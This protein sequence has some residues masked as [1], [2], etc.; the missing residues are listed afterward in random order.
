MDDCVKHLVEVQ[1][2][3]KGLHSFLGG[4]GMQITP[5]H[6]PAHGCPSS[7]FLSLKTA[8]EWRTLA[9]KLPIP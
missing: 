9:E 8:D 5:Y 1:A 6:A 7:E 4:K 3:G 2:H